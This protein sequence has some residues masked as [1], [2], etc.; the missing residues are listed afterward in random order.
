[1]GHRQ[2][3]DEGGDLNL[4]GGDHPDGE[5]EVRVAGGESV[6]YGWFPYQTFFYQLEGQAVIEVEEKP[7]FKPEPIT[8]VEGSCFVVDCGVRYKICR[9]KGSIGMVVTNNPAGNKALTRESP[10]KRLKT[11][12][13]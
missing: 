6:K 13:Q 8:L 12:A 10:A 3:L 11:G 5:F 7:A 2:V 9:S 1:M 4:F